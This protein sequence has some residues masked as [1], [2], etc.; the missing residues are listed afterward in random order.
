M[1]N[2]YLDFD[3][4]KHL[5]A[6]LLGN[7][8][9]AMDGT[10]KTGTS[11]RYARQDHVHPSDTTKVDKVSGKGLSTNDFTNAYK[12]LLDNLDPEGTP[13]VIEV[14]KVN[15]T[16]QAVDSTDKSVDISVPT[17][18]SQLTNDSNFPVDASYVH[19][20]NNFTTALKNKLNSITD[21]LYKNK[22]E[23]IKTRKTPTGSVTTETIDSSKAVTL[24]IPVVK[25]GTA[26]PT[27]SD[28]SDGEIY[29]RFGTQQ[30]YD[31]A[32]QTTDGLMSAADKTK[33]DAFGAASNYALKSDITAMYKYK[34]SVATA[35][36]LP[37]TGQTVGDVYNIEAASVYG[38]EGMNVAWNGTAWD[39]LGEIFSVSALTN[40]EIDTAISQAS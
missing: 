10:A 35:A 36:A 11:K 28:I 34:G 24:T 20:D 5:I 1:A 19:T 13:N 30:S 39:P 7:A 22:L 6:S 27:T 3:G 18:T 40:T 26:A 4:L 16:A 37:S 29:L 14:I 38:G 8:T 33:L 32:T 23:A 2:S 21:A 31:P 17:K 12:D 25:T 15:G 9:P